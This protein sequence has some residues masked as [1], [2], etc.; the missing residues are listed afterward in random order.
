MPPRHRA[1]LCK[2]RCGVA[3]LRIETGRYEGLAVNSRLCPFCGVVEDEVHALVVCN[4][5]SDIR[6][7]LYQKAILVS[8]NFI[9]LS[10]VDKLIVL[11]DKPELTRAAAKAC[12]DILSRRNFF[13]CKN[14]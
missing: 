9:D 8:P 10:P 12:N 1:A 14:T 13:L 11:L 3:P 2:F 5:Y 7:T 4:M 6:N